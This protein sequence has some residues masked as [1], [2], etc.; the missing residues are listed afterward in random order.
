MFYCS[1]SIIFML[2]DEH[3]SHNTYTL[4]IGHWAL[5]VEVSSI[6]CIV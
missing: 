6:E 4:G 3:A 2:V 5:G 1:L